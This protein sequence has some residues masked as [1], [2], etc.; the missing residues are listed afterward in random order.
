M[1]LNILLVAATA[2]E[3]A[4]LA[5]RL[6]LGAQAEDAACR[7]G[8]LGGHALSLLVTGIGMGNTAAHLA[9]LLARR[10]Y[11]LAINLGICGSYVGHAPG[12]VVE[13]AEELYGDLGATDAAGRFLDL[14]Q[15]GF[16]LGTLGGSPYYNQLVNPRPSRLPVPKVRGLTANTV[17]GDAAL[18]AQRQQRWQPEVE[19]MESAAFFQLCLEHRLRFYAFRAVSNAVAGR[20]RNKWEIPLAIKKLE[21]FIFAHLM[22]L[23]DEAEAGL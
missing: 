13:I 23:A 10:P 3:A 8:E 21:E 19:T 14:G 1:K 11:H 20:D 18:I 12:T 6:G 5:D 4:G 15:L 16:P 17:A 22:L 7:E 2:G 9:Q